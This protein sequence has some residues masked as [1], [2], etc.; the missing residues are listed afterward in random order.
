MG[1]QNGTHS[2]F[3]RISEL[4]RDLLIGITLFL[5]RFG[6]LYAFEIPL[7]LGKGYPCAELGST[8]RLVYVGEL[9]DLLICEPLLFEK[10]HLIR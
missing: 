2:G 9:F 3:I 4:V 7:V 6:S 8:H 5:H 1:V 10:R